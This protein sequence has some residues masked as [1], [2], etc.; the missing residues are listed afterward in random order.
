MLIIDQLLFHNK[1]TT[2]SRHSN[3]LAMQSKTKF[4]EGN[5]VGPKN[6]FT[7]P[8]HLFPDRKHLRDLHSNTMGRRKQSGKQR[9][10]RGKSLVKSGPLRACCF[11]ISGMASLRPRLYTLGDH[12][13]LCSLRVNGAWLQRPF[14]LCFASWVEEHGKTLPTRH[15][16]AH[17]TPYF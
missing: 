17:S 4:R 6:Q 7:R 10:V 16:Q 5:N 11:E 12:L 9:K 3:F 8:I 2:S 1:S 15:G 13:Q 14:G